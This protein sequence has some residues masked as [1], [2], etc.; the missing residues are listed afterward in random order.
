[1]KKSTTN[2]L[3]F[4]AL[5]FLFLI[6]SNNV[7]AV[8]LKN[9]ESITFLIDDSKAKQSDGWNGGP[10]FYAWDAS[11]NALAGG[12]PGTEI[13]AKEYIIREGTEI[14]AGVVFSSKYDWGGNKGKTNDIKDCNGAAFEPNSTYVITL[15]GSFSGDGEN[16]IFAYTIEKTSGGGG[17]TGN[18]KEPYVISVYK[19]PW[20]EKYKFT[21]V[22][23]STNY[24]YEVTFEIP[25]YTGNTSDYGFW[26]GE[27]D[28]W[29]STYSENKKISDYVSEGCSTGSFSAKI[30]ALNEEGKPHGGDYKNYGIHD[31]KCTESSAKLTLTSSVRE[32]DLATPPSSITLTATADEKTEGNYIWYFS[33]DSGATYKKL[34]ETTENTLELKDGNIPTDSRW[35]FKV[36]R[37][38]VG[39][40]TYIEAVCVI[41]TV[42]SCGE[43][44]KG[45]NIFHEDF[46]TL[47]SKDSRGDKSTYDG[48][49]KDYTYKEAPYKVNDGSYSVVANPYY[50]GCGDGD[51]NDGKVDQDCINRI[52][53]F[54][55]LPDHTIYNETEIGPYGG[56][57]LINFKAKGNAYERELTDTETKNIRKNSI[58]TFSAYFASAAEERDDTDFNPINM[59]MIIQFQKEGSTDWDNVATISSQVKENEGWQRS[60]VA[61]TVSDDKGK[62]RV[63]IDNHGAGT[64]SGNDLLV[65]DIKLDLCTPAFALY[66]VDKD[67]NITEEQKAKSIDDTV[68]VQV[69]QID[70][71]SLGA[72]PCMQLYQRI[73]NGTDTSYTYLSDLTLSEGYYIA[74]VLANSVFT[75]VP[76]TVEMVAVASA[77]DN[78]ACAS[79]VKT[80]VE[81]GTYKPG[82]QTNVVFSGNYLTYTIGCGTS[83][84]TLSEG[85]K[86]SI[87]LTDDLVMP[88][89]TL[90]STNIG[91]VVK[92]DVLVDDTAILTDIPYSSEINITELYKTNNAGAIYKPEKGERTITVKVREY[93]EKGEGFCERL[94]NGEVKIIVLGNSAAPKAKRPGEHYSYNWCKT[95][96]EGTD[97]A[98]YDNKYPFSK[99]IEDTEDKTGLVWLDKDLNEID[100]ENAFFYADKVQ[101]DSVKV[102]RN[103]EGSCPSDIITI[104]YRVKEITPNPIFNNYKECAIEGDSIALSSLVTN[105][106]T[107]KYLQFFTKIGEEV[108][109]FDPS[110]V[111]ETKYYINASLDE[112]QSDTK[113]YCEAKDSIYVTVKGY[114]TAANILAND[115]LVCPKAQLILKAKPDFDKEQKNVKYTWYSDSTIT[116][117]T[118]AYGETFKYYALDEAYKENPDTVYVTVQSDDYCEN[119]RTEAKPV[120]ISQKEAVPSLEITPTS[121]EVGI[122]AIPE[123]KVTPE[124]AKYDLYVNDVKV[125]ADATTY[126]PYIDSEYKLVYQGECGTS[127]ASANV[128]VLWPTVFTP[129]L[130]DGRN[131]TFVKDMDP[132]FKTKIF[133]RFGTKVYESDNGWD[134]SVEGALN[135]GSGKK[136]VPGVYYYVVELP[137]GNVK[138][139]TIEVFKY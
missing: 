60:Q 85:E 53:W 75:E 107:Y 31:F 69:Q 128:T 115:T 135:G 25:N 61:W 121:A 139:G 101:D 130:V 92:M 96:A 93:N 72:D 79:S 78:G 116:R 2:F 67:G 48:I 112:I 46:G 109:K 77:K 94:A 27:N 103:P 124:D 14:P 15:T 39:Q 111:G 43:D 137:D 26:V 19:D 1:M 66:F 7:F 131:D 23:G 132:N 71:G 3:Q 106:D 73:V 12:W 89:L 28:A 82:Q 54:R 6:V 17:G 95:E 58:L 41:Y 57:L 129:H 126:K 20:N 40:T 86:S 59:E 90:S 5:L 13:G 16:R 88:K 37:K 123:F 118:L 99:L 22:P 10:Y 33:S 70:F 38:I 102:Y 34:G 138:K 134:G 136:A 108:T 9:G 68:K 74:E 104:Y 114:A 91:T 65:D 42:Q 35:D 87:C 11:D 117:R 51:D 105:A 120:I 100:S 4:V 44:T 55:D 45:S 76:G 119:I 133:T 52:Q 84:L 127:T 8:K 32:F 30:Y 18:L 81:D 80:G 21:P 98:V 24:E 122:G 29:S 63:V 62:F 50:S 36:E 47:T 110:E 125:S 49:V 97:P 56:M 83:L 113:N 64:G